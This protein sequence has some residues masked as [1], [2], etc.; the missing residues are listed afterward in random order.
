MEYV[1]AL[2]VILMY[3]DDGCSGRCSNIND[4]DYSTMSLT[5]GSFVSFFVLG[6]LFGFTERSL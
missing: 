6:R 2:I 4:N 1:V 5:G 3:V